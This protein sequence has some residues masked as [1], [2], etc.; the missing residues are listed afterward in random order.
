MNE[1]LRKQ[2]LAIFSQT[3]DEDLVNFISDA[4]NV[5][6]SRKDLRLPSNVKDRLFETFASSDNKELLEFIS[7]AFMNIYGRVGET[8]LNLDMIGCMATIYVSIKSNP[9]ACPYI[10]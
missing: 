3:S 5:L 4:V 8:N 7:N 6:Y 1:E 10:S 2:L 9:P